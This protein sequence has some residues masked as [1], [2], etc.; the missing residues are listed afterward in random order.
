MISFFVPGIPAPKGSAK[1]FVVN[2]R[3]VVTHANKRTKPWEQAIIAAALEQRFDRK[4]DAPFGVDLRFYLPRP[5]SHYSKGGLAKSAPLFPALKKI[6]LD[7]GVR[8][9]LDALTVAGVWL[10]DSRVVSLHAKKKYEHEKQVPGLYVD[11]WRVDVE[12]G[13][14]VHR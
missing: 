9:V 4:V 10:D 3:A 5:Q 1:G 6:D 7:K 8:A 2:G 14:G 11:V 13:I 12:D